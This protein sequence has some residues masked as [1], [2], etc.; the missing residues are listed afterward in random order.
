MSWQN[1]LNALTVSLLALLLCG[2]GF[3]PLY[4]RKPASEGKSQM[5]AGVKIDPIE[6]RAGQIFRSS[7]E[8]RL[9][10]AGTSKPAYRLN[11]ALHTLSTPIGVAR[12]GTVSRYNVHLTS[13]YV[14]TRIA[15]DKVIASDDISYIDSYN[16]LTPAYYS[17]YVSEQD[18]IKRGLIELSE[19]YRQRLAVYLDAGAPPQPL[20]KPGEKTSIQPVPRMLSPEEATT[21]KLD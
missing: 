18:S 20:R 11:V 3:Q 9:N 5:M 21:I 7:L 2:C 4:A 14:L 13:R 15:D 19:L 1:K 16:N 12:D 6:G 8:D 10:P 17:T